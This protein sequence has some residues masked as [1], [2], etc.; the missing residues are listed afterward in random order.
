MLPEM[1]KDE[2]HSAF[3]ANK[4]E[5]MLDTQPRQALRPDNTDNGVKSITLDG[6][7]Q[8]SNAQWN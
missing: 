1:E 4:N 3:S 7:R 8:R 6:G 2:V 5:V